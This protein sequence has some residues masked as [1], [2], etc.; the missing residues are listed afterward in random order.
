[1]FSKCNITYMPLRVEHTL[2]T[3]HNSER[4][5]TS[6]MPQMY[7]VTN[8][9]VHCPKRSMLQTVWYTAPNVPCYKQYGKLPQTF[10]VTNSMVHCPKCSMLQTVLYKQYGTLPQM[11]HVTNSMV[12]C[13][14]R[15]MLQTVWYTAPNVPCYKQY[16]QYGTLPQMYEYHV[17]NSLVHMKLCSFTWNKDG[18][19]WENMR[20]CFITSVRYV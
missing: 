14:K 9:M 20:P 17:T 3:V 1:M 12:H 16:K 19:Y 5:V 18:N 10:H 8:R 15:T 11:Y 13:P 7:H 6:Y 2:F 4:A